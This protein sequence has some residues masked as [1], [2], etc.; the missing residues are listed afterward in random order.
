MK[1]IPREQPSPPQQNSAYA[2]ELGDALENFTYYKLRRFVDSQAGADFAC[3]LATNT[4]LAMHKRH[5]FVGGADGFFRRGAKVPYVCL[6]CGNKE[7]T[8]HVVSCTKCYAEPGFS[9]EILTFLIRMEKKYNVQ[10][11]ARSTHV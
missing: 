2:I 11:A 4:R 5:G 8:F 6:S 3:Y 10:H 7:V 1:L 9:S